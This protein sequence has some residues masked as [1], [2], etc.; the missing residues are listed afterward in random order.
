MMETEV[1]AAVSEAIVGNGNAFSEI[2]YKGWLGILT[3]QGKLPVGIWIAAIVFCALVGYLL[4]SVNFAV[5][6][7]RVRFHDDIRQHGSGNAGATNMNRTYGKGAGLATLAGDILKSVVSVLLARFLCGE[8]VA[9]AVALL[10]AVGHA[11]P[12]YYRFKGGKAVAV[13]AASALV[14]EPFVFLILLLIFAV[15]VGFTK[16]VS[17]GSISAALLY[18]LILHNVLKMRYG[19]GDLRVL[20]VF[21]TCAL[22]IWLH[23]ENIRRLL[24]GQENKL[25]FKKKTGD[26]EKEK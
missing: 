25:R 17:L 7:S 24:N 12:C 15:M 11:F 23:R 14:L 6:I 9:Y 2:L 22:V 21:L 1:T 13:T 18:P 16:Y 26:A 20:F 3:E 4:G 10:C 19:H 8:I 5:V